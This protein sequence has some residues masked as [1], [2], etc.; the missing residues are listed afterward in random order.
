M[1]R[2]QRGLFAL[3]AALALLMLLALGCDGGDDSK[4]ATPGLTSEAEATP[5]VGVTV[6]VATPA[7]EDEPTSVETPADGSTPTATEASPTVELTPIPGARLATIPQDVIAFLTGFG[8]KPVEGVPCAYDGERSLVDCT[9]AGFGL[10]QLS[11]SLGEATNI[12]CAAV[13]IDGEPT[14]VS[15]NST[16]PAFT[17]FYQLE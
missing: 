2:M 8:D 6:T 9:E 1:L 5:A 10:I 7:T 13:L 17:T 12:T 3:G 11:P 16:D 4:G 15:C 14:G